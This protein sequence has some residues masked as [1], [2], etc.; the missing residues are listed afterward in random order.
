MINVPNWKITKEFNLSYGHRV[1][2][3]VLNPEFSID[4]KCACRHLHG[5][6]MTVLVTL[7]GTELRA[8]M[9][10]DFK[11]LNWF[12]KWLD[13]FLDHKFIMDK[14]DPELNHIFS[15]VAF[16][17]EEEF[18]Q[19]FQKQEFNLFTPNMRRFDN[20]REIYEG[21]VI[22]PF[23]PTSELLSMWFYNIVSKKMEKILKENFAQ[24]DSVRIF[25]T[26][27]SSSQFSLL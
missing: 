21:L 7:L 26:S 3:Q 11:H 10:T 2:S 27:K 19:N 9:I 17:S 4:S 8:G 15:C 13:D 23:I 25:E 24:V 14:S 20:H 22:V 12:K 6:N 5:H 1:W 16:N 18:L